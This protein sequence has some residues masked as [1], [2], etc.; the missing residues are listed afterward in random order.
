ML[1]GLC[2]AGGCGTD[3]H[4]VVLDGFPTLQQSTDYTCGPASALAVMQY[5]QRADESE[6]RLAEAMHTHVDS[7]SAGAQPGSAKKLCDYGTSIVELHRYFAART[8]FAIV[9]SSYRP[10]PSLLTDTAAVGIQ[11]VGN[12]TPTFSDYA[13]AADFLREHLE[14][15]RPVMVCWNLWGGHWTV[16]IGYDDRGTADFYDD[17]RLIMADPYD[18][19]DGTADGRTEVSLVAFFYD[20][21]CTMTPKP[22][23]LQPYLVVAP[24][25]IRLKQ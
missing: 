25:S 21:F 18:S 19:T 5:Y 7:D 16:C 9:A 23:Q 6:S 10:S 17:D 11:A 12:A 24:A 2:L 22:W 20:W 1:A 3:R 15:G 8:D 13:L 4:T 14:A